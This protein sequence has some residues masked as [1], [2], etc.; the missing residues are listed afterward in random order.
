MGSN[1]LSI[2]GSDAHIQKIL[3]PSFHRFLH[4]GGRGPSPTESL[5]F[6]IPL[7]SEVLHKLEKSLSTITFTRITPRCLSDLCLDLSITSSRQCFLI[8]LCQIKTPLFVTMVTC[9]NFYCSP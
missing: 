6:I 4:K 5:Q 8:S 9:D 2:S 7:V 3:V 1:A